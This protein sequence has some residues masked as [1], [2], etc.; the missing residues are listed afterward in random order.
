MRTM[1]MPGEPV[2][3]I[4]EPEAE[5]P[6]AAGEAAE[7]ARSYN[8]RSFLFRHEL[9]DNPLFAMSSLRD[10]ARRRGDPPADVYWS[11]AAA[12]VTDRWEKGADGRRSLLDTID[13]IA[14]N[15]AL[16]MLKHVELDPVLAPV[17]GRLLSSMIALAGVRMRE[18]VIVGR[19]TILIAAPHRITAYHL[20]ADTNF[21]F[22][23]AG[24]KTFCV[25]DQCDRTLV[26]DD[27]LERY[28]GGDGNGATFKPER[29]G[30]A[31][32]YQLRPG[33]GVHVPSAAP[34]WAQN[35]N[36][37]SV[38]L[39]LNYDLRSIQREG[40]IYALNRRLRRLGLDPRP[41]G[42]S[43]WRDRIKL[44]TIGAVRTLR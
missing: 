35:G 17:L 15:D 41:P 14:G 28:Y 27:E 20:D 42:Q 22:Q 38:A 3:K 34:H 30:E 24:D 7:F 5:I 10:V 36:T 33:L 16:I 12:A 1:P 32:T 2:P 39:S 11:N 40:R 4:R 21:L 8:R 6:A 37:V 9:S 23:I 44:A 29:R 13:T 43:P 19:A 26:S 31:E 18:D 25:F